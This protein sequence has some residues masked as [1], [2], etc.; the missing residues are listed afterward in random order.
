MKCFCGQFA[1]L[2]CFGLTTV[3]VDSLQALFS[4]GTEFEMFESC[5]SCGFC[6]FG[7]LC[8]FCCLLVHMF[9]VFVVVGTVVTVVACLKLV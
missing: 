4:L 5:Y 8:R 3:F 6:R 1:G 7:V 2:G 9:C